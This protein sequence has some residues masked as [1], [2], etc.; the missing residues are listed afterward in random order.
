[1][2]FRSLGNPRNYGVRNMVS[3]GDT[4][5]IGIANIDDGLQIWTMAE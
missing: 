4:L 1:V 2:L 5:Y 3:T